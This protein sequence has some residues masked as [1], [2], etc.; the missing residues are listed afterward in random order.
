MGTRQQAGDRGRLQEGCHDRQARPHEQPPD[1]ERDGTARLRRRIRRRHRRL[2]LIC[3]EPEPARGKACHVGVHR[4]CAGAQAPRRGARCRRRLRLED[5]HLRRRG[6]LHLGVEEGPPASQVDGR[7]LGILPL[8]R[9]WPRSR[10]ARRTRAR[11]RRED[12]GPAGQDD[13]EPRRLYVDVLVQRADLSLWNAAVGPI[14]SA[15]DLCRGRR[16]LHEHRAGRRLSRRRP[17]GSDVR[18]RTHRR[19]SGPP[20]EARPGGVPP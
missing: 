7:T 20:V 15:R 18:H 3:D 1:P 10:H 14:R 13:R 16:S 12:A 5:F 8:R 6:R 9:A 17:S 11:R 4:P 19:R 2:H